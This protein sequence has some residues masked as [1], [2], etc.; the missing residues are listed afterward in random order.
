MVSV[1]FRWGVVAR[2]IGKNGEPLVKKNTL[3]LVSLTAKIEMGML[4]I[5]LY[6]A[7]CRQAFEMIG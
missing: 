7:K 2:S 4:V 1:Y 5:A 3:F 6:S